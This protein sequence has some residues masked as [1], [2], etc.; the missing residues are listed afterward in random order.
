MKN[1]DCD[2]DDCQFLLES[3]TCT[4]IADLQS[5][6]NQYKEKD[7]VQNTVEIYL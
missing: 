1:N 4:A 7:I 6:F 2:K 5:E 3:K